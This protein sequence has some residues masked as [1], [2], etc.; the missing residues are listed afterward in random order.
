MKAMVLL[1]ALAGISTGLCQAQRSKPMNV[2]EPALVRESRQPATVSIT[3]LRAPNGAPVQEAGRDRGTLL[4]G[5]VSNTARADHDGAQIRPQG[6][7]FEV[8]TRL[9]WRV[10]LSDSKA[11]GSATVSGYLLSADPMRTVWLDGV[12]LSTTPGIIAKNVPYGTTSEHELKVVIP[13]SMP[14]GPMVD[15]IGIVVTP[16]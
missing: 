4:L 14:A 1:W 11:A 7:S 15:L 16:N 6:N 8:S 3:F 13:I 10:D 12:K 2:R 5:S 9:G